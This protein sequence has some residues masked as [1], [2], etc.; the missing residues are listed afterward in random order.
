MTLNPFIAQSLIANGRTLPGKTAFDFGSV[1][2]PTFEPILSFVLRY[3]SG[4]GD[5]INKYVCSGNF[6]L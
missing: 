5:T 3:C 6:Y 1:M 2:S 4:K